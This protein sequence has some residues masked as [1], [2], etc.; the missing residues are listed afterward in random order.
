MKYLHQKRVERES[1]FLI[2]KIKQQQKNSTKS[3]GDCDSGMINETCT[4][5]PL[6]LLVDQN[7]I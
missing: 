6:T 1:I 2:L 7:I 4:I 5:M 3:V